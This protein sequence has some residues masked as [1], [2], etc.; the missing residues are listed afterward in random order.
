MNDLPK[1]AIK[2]PD[3][4]RFPMICSDGAVLQNVAEA[5]AKEKEFPGSFTAEDLADPGLRSPQS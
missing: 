4:D 1:G 5:R 3:D 2:L